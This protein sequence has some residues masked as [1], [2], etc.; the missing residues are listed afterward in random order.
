MEQISLEK[1]FYLET[2]NQPGVSSELT[3]LLSQNGQ[4]IKG[5]WGSTYSGKG[6]FAFITESQ[7]KAKEVLQSSPF[8]NFREEDFVVA[9]TEDNTGSAA[10]FTSKLAKSN[11]NINWLYTTYYNGKPAIVFSS[12][13]NSQALQALKH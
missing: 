5:I 8:N 1:G 10:A 12:D 6:H 2:A 9:Y 7:A 4:N 11:V 13:D 3:S